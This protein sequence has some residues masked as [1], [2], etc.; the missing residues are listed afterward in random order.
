M[1]CVYIYMI[2]NRFFFVFN[3]ISVYLGSRIFIIIMSCFE[4]YEIIWSL[5]LTTMCTVRMKV[6]ENKPIERSI[7]V[8]RMICRFYLF[9]FQCTYIV[10][11]IV[12]VDFERRF[13]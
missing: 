3:L 11:S 5:S 9:V 10:L 1:K 4:G 12:L 7:V 8:F 2:R 13:I 6:Y